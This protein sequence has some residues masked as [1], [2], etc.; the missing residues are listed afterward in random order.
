MS[1]IDELKEINKKY[2]AWNVGTNS[3]VYYKFYKFLVIHKKTEKLS[4]KTLE[5]L[6][7]EFKSATINNF[8]A[9]NRQ[10]YEVLNL[11]KLIEKKDDKYEIKQLKFDEFD[12]DIKIKEYVNKQLKSI[13]NIEQLSDHQ[14]KLLFSYVILYNYLDKKVTY[15]EV[16][17]LKQMK[18]NIK[19]GFIKIY[20][21]GRNN[22]VCNSRFLKS[23]ERSTIDHLENLLMNKKNIPIFDND[24]ITIK[25]S[26]DENIISD[27]KRD[28]E[29]Q[30]K[31]RAELLLEAKEH[32]QEGCWLC[33]RQVNEL[34]EA[35]HI[36]PFSKEGSF[37]RDN[38]MLLCRNHHSLF[39]NNYFLIRTN[40]R[41]YINNSIDPKLVENLDIN[42]CNLKR[43]FLTEK[44]IKNLKELL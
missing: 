2:K 39:D 24:F 22:P 10:M 19:K 20:F 43:E 42:D 4:E 12:Y 11:C 14:K 7:N 15:D 30:A 29:K 33:G 23:L 1:K 6:Y 8:E 28:Q 9:V 35:A 21:T 5:S 18:G 17:Q 25:E 40:G 44:R 27:N 26:L 36:I 31:F 13:T 38:G 34:L 32:N 3:D 37:E 41:V 16:L